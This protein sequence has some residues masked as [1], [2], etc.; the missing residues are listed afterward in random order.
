MNR[1]ETERF[2]E[3][4]FI[5]EY[6]ENA[7]PVTSNFE[8]DRI[9]KSSS[10][11]KPVMVPKSMDTLLSTYKREKMSYLGEQSPKERLTIFRNKILIKLNLEEMDELDSIIKMLN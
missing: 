1:L 3:E 5:N 10:G 7:I 2:V 11:Y 4:E 9:L 8:L 6:G